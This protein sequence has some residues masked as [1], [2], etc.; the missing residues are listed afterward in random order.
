[1]HFLIHFV[2]V[3]TCIIGGQALAHAQSVSFTEQRPFVV[4]VVPV[5]GNGAVGGVAIDA[6]GAIEQAEERDVVALR[7]ARRAALTGLAG[8]V[9][10]P[11]KLRK[12][13]LR[14]LDAL[15]AATREPEQAAAVG[16]ALSRRFAARR[17]RVR[18]S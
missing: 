18:L 10:R 12:I 6:K 2:V 5:V 17:V 9:T 16:H 11:S 4:G 3:S 13:S 1:M 7:D 14:R 15:L 8:D